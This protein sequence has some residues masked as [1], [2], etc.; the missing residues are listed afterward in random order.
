MK[1]VAQGHVYD[2]VADA[3]Q[4]EIFDPQISLPHSAAVWYLLAI[5]FEAR[6]GEYFSLQCCEHVPVCACRGACMLQAGVE[7]S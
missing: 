3:F 1:F 7:V 5:R 6:L 4:G 2:D